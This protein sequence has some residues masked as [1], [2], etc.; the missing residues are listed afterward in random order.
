MSSENW[1]SGWG[2]V[3]FA[4]WHFA[5]LFPTSEPAEAKAA[6]MGQ[7]YLVKYGD[8]RAGSEEFSCD[9]APPRQGD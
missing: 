6:E 2:V 5:G 3:R 1:I 9:G 7:G 8:L 4:P